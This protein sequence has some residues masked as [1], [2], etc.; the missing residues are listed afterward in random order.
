[1]AMGQDGATAAD[2]QE[3]NAN[4]ERSAEELAA[5]KLALDNARRRLPLYEQTLEQ[6]TPT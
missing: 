2:K 1:M 6:F 4:L 3:A 5:A